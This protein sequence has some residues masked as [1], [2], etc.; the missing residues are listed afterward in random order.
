M[1]NYGRHFSVQDY[2]EINYKLT[3]TYVWIYN[4]ELKILKNM[5]FMIIDYL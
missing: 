1:L 5:T 4:Q 2:H 3:T